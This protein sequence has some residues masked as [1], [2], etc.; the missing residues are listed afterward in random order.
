MFSQSVRTFTKQALQWTKV[1]LVYQRVTL[2][3]FTTLFFFLAVINCVVLI[4][5]QSIAFIDNQNADEMISGFLT[6]ANITKTRIVY[7][8]GDELYICKDLP[9]QSDADCS[10]LVSLNDN[11]RRELGDFVLIP[12]HR[13][14]NATTMKDSSGNI[15]GLR[16]S[17]GRVLDQDCLQSLIWLDDIMRDSMAEDIVTLIFQIWLFLLSLVAILNESLPHLGAAI[18]GHA[19]V[20]GWAG[21][22]IENTYKLESHYQELIVHQLCNDVDFLGGWWN[23]RTGHSIPILVC[24]VVAF[25]MATYLASRLYRVYARQS[26]ELVGASPQIHQVYKSVLLLSVCVQLGGFFAIASTAMWLA[27][28]SSGTIALVAKNLNLYRAVFS[29][30]AILEVPWTIL[31]WICFR[32]ESRRQFLIFAGISLLLLAS[33]SGIFASPLYQFIF[34]TWPFFATMTI[35]SYLLVVATFFLSI[36]CR[37]QFGKGLPEYLKPKETLEGEDFTPVHFNDAASVKSEKH[38]GSFDESFFNSLPP[39]LA[40][41]TMKPPVA[42]FKS[43]DKTTS[44]Y[45]DMNR[46]TMKLSSTPPLLQSALSEVSSIS[47]EPPN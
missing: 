2:T 32:R 24:N 15:D 16:L 28:A 38:P 14:A 36:W 13:L 5:L 6:Q 20:T 10:T 21:Y 3:R 43:R 45:S 27:K 41:Q 8:T 25:V 7:E 19:L 1:K 18:A 17:N 34:Q 4:L 23:L 39:L 29:I 33:S 46:S 40:A 44:V 11:S 30:M 31:G 9:E 22:R 42:H 12:R 37:T 47:Q 35:T 26:F